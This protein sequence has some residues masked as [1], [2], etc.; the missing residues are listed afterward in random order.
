MQ[1]IIFAQGVEVKKLES[2]GPQVRDI[3]PYID[4]YLARR[5][6]NIL[7]G[8]ENVHYTHINYSYLSYYRA[9][10]LALMWEILDFNSLSFI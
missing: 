4:A 5:S 2:L 8:N 6:M 1:G 3:K 10:L 7:V 9:I